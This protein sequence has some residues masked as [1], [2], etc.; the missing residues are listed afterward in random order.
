M[1]LLTNN[2]ND[3]NK[4]ENIKFS[5]SAR[6]KPAV[7]PVRDFLKTEYGFLRYDQIDTVYGFTEDLV[8]LYGGRSFKPYFVL[9]EQDLNDM[10]EDGIGLRLP[11][12][13]SLVDRKDYEQ[14][15]MFLEKHHRKGNDVI[16]TVKKLAEWIREDYPLY[17][18]DCS[19]IKN[20]RPNQIDNSFKDGLYDNTVLSARFN[21]APEIADIVNKD[22]V[23]IFVNSKCGW[24]C[25]TPTC[26]MQVSQHNKG[27]TETFSCSADGGTEKVIFNLKRF[28]DMGFSHF[29]LTPIN[30][31]VGVTLELL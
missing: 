3:F 5:V 31:N 4:F 9:T 11:L 17:T 2:Y 8:P 29:K 21:N 25:Q 7:V 24:T 6:N 20:Y 13:S 26:Y 15:R 12:S 28:I 22:K 1:Q 10:Y 19:T 18:I 14:S 16:I 30:E 27:L 23:I